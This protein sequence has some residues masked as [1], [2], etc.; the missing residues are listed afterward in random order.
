MHFGSRAERR[1]RPRDEGEREHDKRQTVK[2]IRSRVD[3]GRLHVG[4]IT[5]DSLP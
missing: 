5:K 4:E 1:L 3:V 2:D